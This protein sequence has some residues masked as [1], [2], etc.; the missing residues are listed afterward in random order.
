MAAPER[1]PKLT[2][3][4]AGAVLVA[5]TVLYDRAAAAPALSAE[6]RRFQGAA[7]RVLKLLELFPDAELRTLRDYAAF[8]MAGAAFA[9]A[10]GARKGG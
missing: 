7:T 3:A 4:Q 10:L 2:S 8:E 5:A 1:Q 9:L 6:Q